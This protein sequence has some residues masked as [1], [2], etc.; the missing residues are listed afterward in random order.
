MSRIKLFGYSGVFFILFVTGCNS[1]ATWEKEERQ[2]ISDYLKTLPEGEAV[3]KPSGLYLIQSIPGTGRTPVTDDTVFFRYKGTFLNGVAFDSI[4]IEKNLPYEYLIGSGTIVSGV[5]EGL[6]YMQAGGRA[7]FLT[8]SKLAYGADGI[9]GVVPG[10]TPLL[11]V[12]QLDS[13][14]AGSGKK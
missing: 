11:W 14:K 6:R 1:T 8:P 4:S 10:Y 12:I 2:Q 3:L 7:I 9:W 5:D 13:V